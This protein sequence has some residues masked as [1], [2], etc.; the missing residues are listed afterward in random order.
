MKTALCVL[1]LVWPMAASGQTVFFD[2]F[3]GNA[4]LPHWS[5]PP[6]SHW[7][8]NVSNSMLNVTGLF[9]PS[10]PQLKANGASISAT[11]ERQADF[12]VDAW[13]GWE[14]IERHGLSVS[15]FG[16][17]ASISYIEGSF[18]MARVG[19]QVVGTLSMPPPGLQQFTII[20]TGAQFEFLFNGVLFGSVTSG[21]MTP[22]EGVGIGFSDWYPGLRNLLHI[23][24]V[25]VTP[26]PAVFAIPV[27][28]L[29]CPGRRKR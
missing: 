18:V 7:E 27:L 8:Y 21:P 1:A 4:L 15:V 3:E 14:E 20:R 5:Q 24:R 17:S 6:P 10:N 13:M 19:E 26:S 28:G 22:A 12:R 16:P 9:Y 2:D 29:A 11:F 25:Q 23:D